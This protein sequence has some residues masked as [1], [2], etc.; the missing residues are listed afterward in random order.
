MPP[1]RRRGQIIWAFDHEGVNGDKYAFYWDHSLG[2]VRKTR[3]GTTG[4]IRCTAAYAGD[5]EV[6]RPPLLSKPVRA[7]LCREYPCT[8]RWN[9]TQYRSSAPP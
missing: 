9:T 6:E 3:L 1:K 7:H 2:T 8:A 5:N 4:W